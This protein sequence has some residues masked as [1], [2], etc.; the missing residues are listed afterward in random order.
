MSSPGVAPAEPSPVEAA[1]EAYEQTRRLLFPFRFERWLTLGFVAFLDQCGRGGV[2]GVLPGGP[3][4][5]F[6]PSAFGG[7]GGGAEGGT[8]FFAHLALVLA[9][10]AV[11][12]L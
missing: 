1:R 6:P 3:R 4:G 10:A 12:L 7:G 9:V 8:W 2:G 11:L 5:A